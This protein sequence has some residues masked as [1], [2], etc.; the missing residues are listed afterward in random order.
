MAF[1][2]D[3]GSISVRNVIAV[4]NYASSGSSFL[5][6][7]LD[8]HPRLVGAPHFYARN[9]FRFW[10][11]LGD[12]A[13]AP[14]VVAAFVK[15]HAHWFDPRLTD[16]TAGL[17]RLGPSRDYTP[18]VDRERFVK[19]LHCFLG[20]EPKLTRRTL[21]IGVHLAYAA[22]LDRPATETNVDIVFPV[23]SEPRWVAEALLQD[24]PA[25]K[26]IHTVRDTRTLL[27]SYCRHLIYNHIGVEHDPLEAAIKV[28]ADRTYA[29]LGGYE[30][31]GELPYHRHLVERNQARAIRLEDLHRH[32]E[33][34]MRAL[35]RWLDLPWSETLLQSTFD[36]REWWNRP[37][38]P[39][40]TGFNPELT[41]AGV[42]EQ[43]GCDRLRVRW[44][45]RRR[46]RAW[47]YLPSSGMAN[48]IRELT[49]DALAVLTLPLPW[50]PLMRHPGSDYR[51]LRLLQRFT[52]VLPQRTGRR[53]ADMLRRETQRC[54]YLI[55]NEGI[56]MVRQRMPARDKDQPVFALAML[57]D[58]GGA[59]V[60]D[61]YDGAEGT[62][63]KN[64]RLAAYFVNELHDSVERACMPPVLL[65][66][67]LLL[68]VWHYFV[69]RRLMIRCAWRDWRERR[70]FVPL[71]EIHD[72]SPGSAP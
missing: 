62:A 22:G 54:R 31:F 27:P 21:F 57:E 36:G 55:W 18:H 56:S 32:P 53:L 30:L 10:A 23:H 46:L 14:A 69:L 1:V 47:G 59:R 42:S 29:H 40:A 37:E 19:D 63:G 60:V 52:A 28:V 71:L 67:R 3:I 44:L 17:H 66:G 45:T 38:R 26:F 41:T 13:N 70:D 65:F 33:R 48:W 25:A 34:T 50:G 5:Q 9:F 49:D 61:L 12:T 15:D 6:S 24:F 72:T 43:A 39:A 11:Q 35:A 4:Q 58:D 8:S 68:A 64:D 7:L 2:E 20:N 51:V 16:Y